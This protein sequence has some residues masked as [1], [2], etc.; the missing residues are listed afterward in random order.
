MLGADRRKTF[1]GVA[2]KGGDREIRR[3]LDGDHRQDAVLHQPVV[4]P[5]THAAGNQDIDS[6]QWCRQRMMLRVQRGIGG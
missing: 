5:G 4:K 3:F 2:E 6:R 1:K